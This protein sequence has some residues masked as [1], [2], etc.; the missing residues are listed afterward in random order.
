VTLVP[1]RYT[2]LRPIGGG[3]F[4]SVYAADDSLLGRAVAI[5]ILHDECRRDPAAQARFAREVRAGALLGAHPF[6]V[7]LHDAGEWG[8]QPFLVMELLAGSVAERRE[9]DEQLALRW[10]VQAADALDYAHAHGIVHRDVKPANLLLDGSGDVRLADFGVARD[11]AEAGVTLPG[12]VVGTPGYVAPEVEAGGPA[13]PASDIYALAVVGRELLG[14]RDALAAGLDPDPAR[15]PR[16]AGALVRALGGGE[17]RTRVLLHPARRLPPIPVTQPVPAAVRPGRRRRSVRVSLAA[18]AIA[19]LAACSAA[20]AAF[21]VQR[22]EPHGDARAHAASGPLE[23]CA[24]S[25]FKHDANIVVRGARA[26]SFCRT[27]AHVLQLEG[28]RWSYR[29]GGELFAPDHG[30]SALRVVCRLRHGRLAAT[31]YD[32]GTTRIGNDVCSWY[33]SGGWA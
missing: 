33:S 7:T 23:T 16:T 11:S 1:P 31:V 5:K 12:H 6:V 3:S 9:V 29:N 26:D 24:L 32:S 17:P 27:Q 30:L 22:F 8:G 21:L 10:L 15:R 13:T 28:D 20:G 19:A 25:P 4:A 2:S 18:A 14:V